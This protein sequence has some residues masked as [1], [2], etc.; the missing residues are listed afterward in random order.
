MVERLEGVLDAN[1]VVE[2]AGAGRGAAPPRGVFGAEGDEGSPSD[3]DEDEL[4]EDTGYE[5][6]E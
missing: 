4:D 6:D 1:V 2:G 5:G 3:D